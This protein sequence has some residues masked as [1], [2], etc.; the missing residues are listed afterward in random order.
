[1][2]NGELQCVCGLGAG[3]KNGR[4]NADAADEADAGATATEI[5]IG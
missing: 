1:M 5:G 4:L 2:M 3:I